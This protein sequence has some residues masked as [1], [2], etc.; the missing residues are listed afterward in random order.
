MNKLILST[1][2]IPPSVELKI[3]LNSEIVEYTVNKHSIEIDLDLELGF[4]MLSIQLA[5]G[6]PDTNITIT[7]ATLD[8]ISFRQTLY[9]MFGT[10]DAGEKY[11]S[12]L[13]NFDTKTL[14]L[15]FINPVAS[16]IALT[17]NKITSRLYTQKLYEELEVYFPESVIL[18]DQ[19]P[20]LIRDYFKYNL[21]FYV[22]PK[23]DL[24]NPYCSTTVP[25]SKV[26]G[27][28]YDEVGLFDEI[29][30]NLEYLQSIARIPPQGDLNKI[31]FNSK[32][33]WSVVEAILPTENYS[34]ETAFLLDH[35]RMPKVYSLFKSLNIE[36]ILHGFIGVLP[37]GDFIVPHIDHYWGNESVVEK[38][39]GC[40]QIYIPINFK[41]G[42]YFK[43][44]NIGLVPL[45][46]GPVMVNNHNFS[47]SVVNDSN[48]YRFAIAIIGSKF[49][50]QR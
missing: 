8:G 32:T 13:L 33:V 30:E 31:E 15:P 34:L 50:A 12:T 21:D 37:P 49:D 22:H 46:Q 9:T 24:A 25:W 47:H 23:K 2:S 14:H 6:E 11:Q 29:I 38:Y 36:E 42:N 39:P 3:Q 44:T 41:P 7:Q 26:E 16:W 5:K 1:N 48:E 45:D 28:T 43:L 27:I 35:E 40:S 20:K 19:Y 17:A 10:N 4:Y 18:S